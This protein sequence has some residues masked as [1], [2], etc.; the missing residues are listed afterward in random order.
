MKLNVNSWYGRLYLSTY[1]K[2]NTDT[3]PNNICSFF[4]P[5]LFAIILFPLC[6]PGHVINLFTPKTMNRTN[7][8]QTAFH[9]PASLFF[10]IL[11]ALTMNIKQMDLMR[12]YLYGF[13]AF[14]F[15]FFFIFALAFACFYISDK[16]K[17][18]RPLTPKK[19]NPIVAGFRAIKGKYCTP[20]TW[21]RK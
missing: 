19:V 9:L 15:F 20:V 3:L 16:I 18:R 21:E 5:L 8:L 7:A 11:I 12:L 13:M 14:V 2:D 10:G 6:W 1:G 17:E 4:W